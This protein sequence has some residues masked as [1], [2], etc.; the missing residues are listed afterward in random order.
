MKA[1]KMTLRDLDE[2][3]DFSENEPDQIH[4]QTYKMLKQ[5]WNKNKKHSIVDLFIIELT[6]DEEMEEVIL[7]VQEHEWEQ[8]LELGLEHF[9]SVENYEMCSQVKKLLETIKIK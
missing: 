1:K 9:E 6:N 8:A 5:E 7:T 4:N 2:L 3:I